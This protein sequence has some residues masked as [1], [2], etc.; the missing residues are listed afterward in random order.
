M[1]TWKKRVFKPGLSGITNSP[2][3]LGVTLDQT[4]T[5]CLPRENVCCSAFVLATETSRSPANVIARPILSFKPF[6][7]L[8]NKALLLKK[9]FSQFDA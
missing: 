5:I 7:R 8:S 9:P 1:S 6:V 3:L 4:R 2:K